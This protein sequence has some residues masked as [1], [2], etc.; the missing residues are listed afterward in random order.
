V[1]YSLDVGLAGVRNTTGKV[2][3]RV[4][5][6]DVLP[7]HAVSPHPKVPWLQVLLQLTAILP[8]GQGS[9]IPSAE[10]PSSSVSDPPSADP[11][12]VASLAMAVPSDM[13]PLE[14]SPTAVSPLSP[15]SPPCSPE[16][17][18]LGP[19]SVTPTEAVVPV[20]QFHSAADKPAR[21][22]AATKRSAPRWLFIRI[23]FLCPFQD[24]G[25]D[26]HYTTTPTRRGP[27]SSASD[28]DARKKSSAMVLGCDSAGRRFRTC[29]E[30]LPLGL[31][32]GA[33][34]VRLRPA[35]LLNALR[36]HRDVLI[37]Y[38]D[39]Y[40]F[41]RR[42]MTFVGSRI[43]AGPNRDRS[44]PKDYHPTHAGHSSRTEHIHSC[45]CSTPM[46]LHPEP[47]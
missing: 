16:S 37:A 9:S 14:S 33:R 3:D 42:F 47:R 26:D 44:D 23:I 19:P 18:S 38:R 46:A 5:V 34:D 20:E 45:P 28:G 4:T 39:T 24:A 6:K 12:D 27:L 21:P 2:D 32:S 43:F 29:D 11:E 22:V 15:V 35:V 10:A 36:V 13:S 1:Q 7:E 8:V 25:A 40:F 41:S 31:Q 30:S 17:P